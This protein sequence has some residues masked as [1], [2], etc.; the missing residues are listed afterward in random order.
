MIHFAKKFQAY[1]LMELVVVM[2]LMTIT[3]TLVVSKW[4]GR[5][6]NL[7]AQAEGLLSDIR[8]TQNLSMT[9]GVRY[10]LTSTSSTTYQI[11][12]I[13]GTDVTSHTLA[14]G[15][16]FGT[17]SNLPNNLISFT[18]RGVPCQDT[19]SPCTVLTTDASI[20]ITGDGHTRSVV[21]LSGT[22]VAS[23]S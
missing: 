15:I 11:A 17:F 12:S 21:I 9:R 7:N 16:T 23:L 5:A 13:A 19:A 14:Q 8:Y 4:P 20:S 3:T 10:A 22:G 18:T 6:I 1:T 2:V